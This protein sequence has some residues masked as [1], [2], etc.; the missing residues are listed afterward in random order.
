MQLAFP[1]LTVAQPA[2]VL[3]APAPY[4]GLYAFHKYWGKKPAEPLRYLIEHVSPDGGL[5]VDPF[6]GSG[7]SVLEALQAGRR[8]IGIDL[9]PAAVRISRLLA[10]PPPA[11]VARLALETVAEGAKEQI[12]DSYRTV[13]G[14][15]ATHFVWDGT[16]LA[17]VWVQAR[18][19]RT[20]AELTPCEEDL[21]L[22]NSFASYRP[23]LLRNLR[24][25]KNS[26]INCYP[27]LS[28]NDLFTGR[29][30]RNIDLLLAR[31]SDLPPA[32]RE[33]MLLSL[34]AA[35]GQMSRMVFAITNRGKAS[36]RDSGRMEVGSWV[37]GY[38]R[39]QQHFEVNVWNCFERRADKL[40]KA[41]SSCACAH[42]PAVA[43][44]IAK[45]CDGGAKYAIVQGNSLEIL[46]SLP[47]R[48]IDLVLTDPP[49]SDRIP[50]LELSELWNA[51]L[52]E[53][54]SFEPEIVVSN[55]RERGKTERE[56]TKAMLH[57]LQICA[58]KLKES[59]SLVLFFNARER[60]SWAYLDRFLPKA[61]E[62][63]LTYS[64]CFPLVYSASSVVQDNRDGAMK[65]DYGLVFSRFGRG[66]G[67]LVGIPGWVC[68]MPK[69]KT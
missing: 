3:S 20:R 7:V 41:L 23:R 33:A 55:A 36:G 69:P 16:S 31:I 64:G 44:T 21:A 25:F 47:D 28:L 24:F 1:E 49:H 30:L 50:Y 63:G 11:D 66:A 29:A 27:D 2:S 56:Y 6:L 22:L 10:A 4:R 18:E 40:V 34:T 43:G 19:G 14:K 51:V 9:N 15:I 57:F 12:L 5:V 59:G 54:P 8:A 38:W 26:R 67:F 35:V 17:K 48:S 58:P 45:V 62:T 13:G 61:A 46:P 37:I 65:T 60:T 42:G 39:P 32:A 52:G 68:E 53:T